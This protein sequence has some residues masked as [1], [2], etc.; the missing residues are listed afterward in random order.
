M[1]SKERRNSDIHVIE[2]LI[3]LEDGHII[4]NEKID[5]VS[6]NTAEIIELFKNVTWAKRTVMTIAS[7]IIAIGGAYLVIKNWFHWQ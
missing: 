4:L 7:I 5:L 6:A 1:P 2:R 3:K